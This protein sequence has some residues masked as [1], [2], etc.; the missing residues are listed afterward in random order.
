MS[1]S[2]NILSQNYLEVGLIDLDS[3]TYTRYHSLGTNI[4]AFN[5]S[6]PFE[7]GMDVFCEMRVTETDRKKVRKYMSIE[8]LKSAIKK[9]GSVDEASYSKET[10][11]ECFCPKCHTRYV[12]KDRK[13]CVKCI[14]KKKLIT[15]LSTFFVRYKLYILLVF[16]T[17]GL[18]T[19]LGVIAPYAS[20]KVFYD[21]VLKEGGKYY[22]RIGLI[23]AVIVGIRLLSLVINIINGIITARVAARVVCDLKTVIFDSIN[24]LSLSFF[25]GR[26]TGGLMTQ[27]NSDADT[28]YWFFCDGFPYLVTNVIQLVAISVLMMCT[29]LPLALYTFVTVP[30]FIATYKLIFN[31]FSKLHARSL[32]RRRSLNSLISDVFSGM[33]V[34]KAFSHESEETE[35]FKKM[36]ELSAQAET[37][38][39]ISERKI[40]PLLTFMLKIGS[41]LVWYIGGKQVIDGTNG[42]TYGTLM[43]FVAYLSLVYEPIQF[44]SN[45]SNWWAESL[46]ALR[47]L[48]DISESTAEITEKS[49]AVSLGDPKGELSVNN[50]T[51]AYEEGRNVLENVSFTVPAGKTLGIVGRT[52]AG[53]STIANLIMRLYDPKDGNITIDGEDLRDVTLSSLHD[54]IA[55]VSQETYLFRGSIKENIR[56]A[57]P[58]ATDDEIIRAAKAASAHSFIMKYPDGYNTLIGIGNKDLSGGERQ[59]ISIARAILKMP[60]ILIL[61]EATAAMDTQTERSI[62]ASLDK[63]TENRTT[64]VIAHRLSTLRNADNLIV[65]D[66]GKVAEYGTPDELIAKK[67][68][69]HK[70]YT[71][72]T[73][74]LRTIGIEE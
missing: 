62:Q 51:F 18:V 65:I 39:G 69:Y 74:A 17:L 56:Y 43:A 50:V 44:L 28:I 70:L 64:L 63:L 73:E 9:N 2:E 34:V 42:M 40:F 4:D 20:N 31:L 37:E 21:D 59:R 68:I 45:V 15:Q 71:L 58:D 32:S 7:Q 14:D 47:R 55:V 5:N 3:D 67:G 66:K 25:T 46:N 61:D 29:N 22:G 48:F 52:G 26:Q 72:Q 41:F 23:I 19:L 11:K 6:F 53:K 35:R 10:E 27:I 36:N 8:Y 38:L 33:R 57:R 1:I 13:L 16:I 60:K 30:L 54:S 49:D 12:E 24:R